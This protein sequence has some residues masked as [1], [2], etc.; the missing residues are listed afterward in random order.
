MKK[1][2]SLAL[3]LVMVL[4][5]SAVAFAEEGTAQ[6][7]TKYNLK[8]PADNHVY[9]IYQI[10]TGDLSFEDGDPILSNAVYGVNAKAYDKDIETPVAEDVMKALDKLNS[11]S[12]DTVKLATIVNLVDMDSIPYIAKMA[13][14]STRE[15]DAGYY[16]VVD[17]ALSDG[18]LAD[19]DEYSLYIVHVTSDTVLNAKRGTTTSEKKVQDDN[20]T[21]WRDSADY[22]IGDTIPFRLSAKI[23]GEYENFKNG[24]KLTFHDTMSSGLTLDQNSIKVFVGDKQI[25]SGYSVSVPSENDKCTF[26]VHFENLKNIADVS[27]GS[28]IYVYYNATLNENAKLGAAGN[29]NTS[30]ITY[31]TNP[32]AQGEGTPDEDGKT[33]DDTVIVFTY[34]LDVTKFHSE[35]VEGNELTGAEFTLTKVGDS[36]FKMV[37]DGSKTEENP[38]GGYFFEFKHLDAGTYTLTETKT[39]ANYNTMAP[40]E[41]VIT[42]EHTEGD[43]PVLQKLT[44]NHTDKF[45]ANVSTG[46]IAGNIINYRGSSLPETGGNGTTMLYLVGSIMALGAGLMLVTKKRVNNI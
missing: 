43:S 22:G 12:D 33:P 9:D 44:I 15:V 13:G 1:I 11:E 34:E 40:L 39:P 32:N 25:T 45:T 3:V 27:G 6:T 16:L 46:I 8:T 19:K 23:T 26:E 35:A 42:A 10:F 21:T 28:L 37:I 24:Y 18:T 30:N 38:D 17:R 14:N 5:L 41:I 20:D 29:P 7:Y 2:L 4:S 36:T 31:T